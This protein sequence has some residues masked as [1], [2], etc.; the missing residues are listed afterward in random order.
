[1]KNFIPC[2]LVLLFLTACS[3]PADNLIENRISSREISSDYVTYTIKEGA[4]Y[5]DK[6][7]FKPVEFSEL[8]FTV[9]FDSSA[10]YTSKEKINQSDINKLYGFSDNDAHHHQYSARFGWSWTENALHLYT[11]VY[12]G[13]KVE[14]TD[15]GTIDLGTEILCSIKIL[16]EW[17]V[18]RLNDKEVKIRRE[19]STVLGK[20]YMLYP[21]FGG[22]EVAP[23]M[24]TIRIKN[25]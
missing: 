9:Q 7:T 20:G 16:S 1:M 5:S 25:L 6:S 15:L 13:G 8:K 22:D 4:H 18:F 23:H 10:I 2:N 3:K 21:Y 11:Y 14:A 17:Y 12:N 24:V 19:S